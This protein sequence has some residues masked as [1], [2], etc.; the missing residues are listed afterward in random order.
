[1][2]TVIQP[3][4]ILFV[5][6]F[7]EP[8]YSQSLNQPKLVVESGHSSFI[9]SISYSQDGKIIASGSDDGTLIL[10]DAKTG[11]QII[12]LE[13][14]SVNIESYS[15]N[16]TIVFGLPGFG[17]SGVNSI[18]F[19]LDGKMVAAVISVKEVYGGFSNSGLIKVWNVENGELIKSIKIKTYKIQSVAFSHDS[20]MIAA[21][22]DGGVFLLNLINDTQSL[23]K[24]SDYVESFALSPDGTTIAVCHNT[25]KLWNL[26]TG[27]FIRSFVNNDEQINSLAFSPNGKTIASG[28][29][30][31][32]VKLWNVETGQPYIFL[33]SKD[34]TNNER[35][36][37]IYRVMFSN[38]GKFIIS[39]NY[40]RTINIWEIDS[41][42]KIYHFEYNFGS[43]SPYTKGADIGTA[44]MSPDNKNVAESVFDKDIHIREIGL[45]KVSLTLNGK[46]Q[47]ILSFVS[48]MDGTSIALGFANKVEIWSLVEGK[49]LHTFK[50]I[51]TYSNVKQ[52]AFSPD[53]SKIAAKN[54]GQT[55]KLWRISTNQLILTLTDSQTT[56]FSKDWKYIVEFLKTVV[57]VW[58]AENGKLLK[59]FS[60]S[61]PELEKETIRNSFP[62]FVD[63]DNQEAIAKSDKINIEVKESGKINFTNPKS[64]NLIASLIILDNDEWIVT[65]PNGRFDT[66][67]TLDD[68]KGL[69]WLISNQPLNPLSLDIFM[70]QYY[71]PNL[72]PRLLKCTEENNCPKEFKT[73]PSIAEI[74]RVQP[75]VKINEIKPVTNSTDLA[76]VTI[77]VENVTDEVSLSA[78]DKT[79]KKQL[80][81]GVYDLRLF[82]DGQ[83]VGVSTP[84]D[85]LEKFIA[86]A[87]RL[88][89]E[90]KNLK[91]LID[92]PEDKAW[93]E[94]NDIFQIQAE[95]V[96]LV[97]P[98]KIEYTFRN[99]KLPKDGRKEVEF[100]AY[101]FN[102]DKVKST[103][104][105]PFKFKVPETVANNPKKG[106]AYLISIGV[107]ASE[108]S[109]Y[110]LQYAAN[111]ARKMQEIVG[112]RLKTN[113]AQYSEI[114]QI[115]LISDYGKD[116]K[117]SENTAQKA[118]I[119]G[120]F[121]V[122][123]GNEKEISK[124]ILRKI[125]NYAKIKPIE[126]EDTLIISFSGHGYA[127]QAGI[128]YLL[129]FD[130]GKETTKL[131]P[132][133]LQKTISSDEL[134]LWMLDITASEMMMI[135]DAC[136]SSA[137]VQGDGFKP[138]PMGSRGLGQ[139]A[140]DKDMK[141]LSAT[142]A[143]NVALELGSLQQ[144]L[145]SYALIQ[146][147]IVQ[148]WAD[149]NTDKQLSPTEWLSYAENRVPE[150]YQAV[151]DGKLSI[152][153][154]GKPTTIKSKD[155]IIFANDEKSNLNLQQPS[156][157]DFKRRGNKNI[158]FSLP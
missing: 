57:N 13:D 12:T 111:D 107:N 147:G 27:K 84:K 136:H 93:R 144:G 99:I 51:A 152:L 26:K 117:L 98:T 7:V 148:K 127:D 18:A 92:T 29:V 116:G 137:A 139:L 59:T 81:S 28:G 83:L 11:Q 134:S 54:S 157:F 119:K 47:N 89:E 65:T 24:V 60:R 132:E 129:P 49:K 125:P 88:I 100:T 142:Q 17:T 3:M 112:S 145:L 36:S 10:W 109:D 130:I 71:E 149:A 94:A 150:L 80:S 14:N 15:I 68:I 140:Y 156:L 22:I 143:N 9:K 6:L 106:R 115:P 48:A 35:V 19:S 87:P 97:S 1:M 58:D 70:R 76:D 32:K 4:L 67:K 40:D 153:I 110:N 158:L 56:Q 23:L 91:K 133:A 50:E 154:D 86:D 113:L 31:E 16:S 75:N 114:V 43:Y 2:K 44:V 33:D 151:K 61:S 21:D 25:I 52:I 126:P 118:I 30:D 41:R 5:L 122:L 105:E 37:Q 66:N 78:T 102:S 85:K 53:S 39:L 101:A 62:D 120:V 155:E 34:H 128:F 20:Q 74:N 45:N 69:H 46:S 72:L 63:Y 121:S 103:T 141:I 96:K 79:Q 42:K 138:G 123:A 135:I 8:I 104:T 124:E 108:N 77:E 73:L 131:T 82:R 95:N 38:D 90:N 55:F 64:G 146:D